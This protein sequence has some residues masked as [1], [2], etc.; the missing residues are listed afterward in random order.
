M[1]KPASPIVIVGRTLSDQEA[2]WHEFQDELHAQCNG[3]LDGDWLTMVCHVVYPIAFKDDPRH[4]ARLTHTVF[5]LQ[6]SEPRSAAHGAH[7]RR[8]RSNQCRGASRPRRQKSLVVSHLLLLGRLGPRA[9]W[10]TAQSDAA[11]R[12]GDILNALARTCA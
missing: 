5:G 8:P 1:W 6:G 3:K 2:W 7:M 11:K 4:I 9:Y 10:S 12:A